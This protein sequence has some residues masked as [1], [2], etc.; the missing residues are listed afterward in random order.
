MGHP[1]LQAVILACGDGARL[2]PLTEECPLSLLPVL[3]R[4]ILQYQLDLLEEAGF[5]RAL[6]IAAEETSSQVFRFLDEYSGALTLDR[7]VTDGSLD[8][9]DVIR[10]ARDKITGDFVVVPGDLIC[11]KGHLLAAMERHRRRGAALTMVLRE[12]GLEVDKKGKLGRPRRDDEDVDFIGLTPDGRVVMKAPLLDVEEAVRVQ[13]ALLRRHTSVSIGT[14]LMDVGLYVLSQSVL[15]HLEEHRFI[16][17]LQDELAPA[18]VRRQFAPPLPPAPS[19]TDQARG[20]ISIIAPA[21][22]LGHGAPAPVAADYYNDMINKLN[23]AKGAPGGVAAAGA[24]DGG[25]GVCAV[26]LRT[27]ADGGGYCRQART[28]AQY[29]GMTKDLLEAQLQAKGGGRVEGLNRKDQ[30]LIGEGC[31][32]G[33]K[34][35]CKSSVIGRGCTIGARCKINN[36]VVMEGARIGEAC[37]IQNSVICANAGVGDGCNLN[38]CQVGTLHAV[39]AGTKAKGEAFTRSI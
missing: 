19:R 18:L 3:N 26:V 16:G 6:V 25:G 37:T 36:C 30:T 5:H 29:S 20:R 14:S 9:A 13:K 12:E 31:T 32:V 38:D 17:S 15:Q 27:A 28:L 39:A 23:I 4:P 8:T 10:Q 24:G 11:E 7:V 33:E 1:E 21:A 35:T 34:V 2:Y 22:S